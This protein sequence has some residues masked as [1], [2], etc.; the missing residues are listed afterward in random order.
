M[1]QPSILENISRIIIIGDV[2]GDITR[3]LNCLFHANIFSKD[4]P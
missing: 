2:H 4:F 1:D 3:L